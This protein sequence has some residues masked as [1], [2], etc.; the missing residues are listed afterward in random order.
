MILDMS[1]KRKSKLLHSKGLVITTQLPGYTILGGVKASSWMLDTRMRVRKR[2]YGPTA[3]KSG[4]SRIKIRYHGR[5]I[6]STASRKS[7]AM[8]N[9]MFGGGT[10]STERGCAQAVQ[11]Q[12]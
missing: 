10:S 11:L 1:N 6:Q 7:H 2:R 4:G 9:D 3:T 5:F 12:P 8:R